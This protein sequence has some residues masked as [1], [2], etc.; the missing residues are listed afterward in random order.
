MIR[1]FAEGEFYHL[2]NRGTDKRIIFSNEE[3]Y[4]RFILLLYLCNSERPADLK[5]QGPTLDEAIIRSNADNRGEPL[6]DLCVY[7]LM[8][9]HFHLLVRERVEGGISRFMQKLSTGYTMYFNKRYDRSG[10]LFQGKFKATRADTDRYLAYLISYIH[11]NPVKLI[12]PGW[13][14]SGIKDRRRAENFLAEYPHSSF[15]DYS[16]H[17]RVEKCLLNMSALPEYNVT[18]R[19]FKDSVE[20]WLNY[21]TLQGPTL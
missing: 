21:S 16:G 19:D 3:D 20:E 2:Y 14:E 5:L 13:K 9:N 12:E 6:V 18:P 8:P 15:Q 17:D 7:C 1:D 11:L 10:T 4:S